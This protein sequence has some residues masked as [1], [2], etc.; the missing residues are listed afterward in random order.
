MVNISL[1]DSVWIQEE[2]R[3][4][5]L[6]R[7]MTETEI[8]SVERKF[9]SEQ[10]QPKT[11]LLRI[12]ARV[13]NVCTVNEAAKNECDTLFWSQHLSQFVFKTNNKS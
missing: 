6:E 10:E 2:L 13:Y 9:A 12:L 7:A 4:V 1:V 8:F 3:G 11:S 5:E